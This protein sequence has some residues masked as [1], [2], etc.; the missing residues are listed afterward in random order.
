M[1]ISLINFKI[2]DRKP[3]FA[4]NMKID[5][6]TDVPIETANLKRP[7]EYVAQDN[8]SQRNFLLPVPTFVRSGEPYRDKTWHHSLCRFC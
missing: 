3:D 4:R 8:Q 5:F 6:L 7:E 1:K 2:N